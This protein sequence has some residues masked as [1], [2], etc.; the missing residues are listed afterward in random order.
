MVDQEKEKALDLRLAIKI[1]TRRLNETGK[2]C[3]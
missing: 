2:H 1:L 3:S